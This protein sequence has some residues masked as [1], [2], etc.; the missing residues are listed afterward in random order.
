MPMDWGGINWIIADGMRVY[1]FRA[2]T[3]I[4]FCSLGFVSEAPGRIL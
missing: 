3:S 2:C 1:P 4:Q